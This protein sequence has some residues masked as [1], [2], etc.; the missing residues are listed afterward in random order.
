MNAQ[1]GGKSHTRA[2]FCLHWMLRLLSL[3]VPALAQAGLEAPFE[4]SILSGVPVELV[5]LPELK[6]IVLQVCPGVQG[7]HTAVTG[8]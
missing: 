8:L 5:P 1:G 4:L 3:Q 2:K 7:C 6:S